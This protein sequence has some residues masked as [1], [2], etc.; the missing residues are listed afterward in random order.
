MLMRRYMARAAAAA[1]AAIE[2]G[3]TPA[4]M[5]MRRLCARAAR[6]IY[7]ARGMRCRQ[8]LLLWLRRLPFIC[9]I[10]CHYPALRHYLPAMISP[11]LLD[12]TCLLHRHCYAAFA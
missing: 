5:S 7:A 2:R 4:T 6:A 12:Y 8:R 9:Y 11:P 3:A 1:Y 10:Y